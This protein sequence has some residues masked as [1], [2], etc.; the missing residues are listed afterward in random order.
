MIS[1][2]DIQ[3]DVI[4]RH[5]NISTIFYRILW[6]QHIHHGLWSGNESPK[7]AAQQLTEQL[8]REARITE[9]SEIADI[10]CGMGGSSIHLAKQLKCKVTGVTISSF[11][12]RWATWA[13]RMAGVAGRAKFLCEDAEKTEFPAASKDV[14][15][16]VE[17]T[18]HLFDKPAFF[19]KVAG[20]LKPG[21][22]VA[23]CAWLAGD[24]P[25]TE[26]QKKL[27][28]DVCEGFFCPS[29]GSEADYCQWMTDA[30]LKMTQVHD[31]TSRVSRTWEICRDRVNRLGIRRV[32]SWIDPGQIIFIDRFQTLL[33][34]YNTG[35]MKY[36]CFIAEKPV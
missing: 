12:K 36:G 1:C 17:C 24:D 23:I 31:W 34:A 28:Y 29:L 11:Q 15:W 30:G 3:K 4:R 22:R 25:L 8:A 10:G 6:G 33:D 13:A 7:V 35:A 27:V 32:A 9:G 21:G 5:Y 18:E 16:S 14:V 26:P 2:P 19:R 20:W